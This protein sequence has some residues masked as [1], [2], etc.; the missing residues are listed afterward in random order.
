MSKPPE[1]SPWW[2]DPPTSQPTPP[3][4]GIAEGG[5]QAESSIP[6]GGP[7]K[8]QTKSGPPIKIAP[9]PADKPGSPRASFLSVE[10]LPT[11][12][13]FRKVFRE[14]VYPLVVRLNAKPDE[15]GRALP[16]GAQVEVQP[17]VPGA[18]VWPQ[19]Q[20]LKGEE[21][22]ARFW[23]MPL[24]R[25]KLRDG[26]V[27]LNTSEAKPQTIPIP[28]LVKTGR[29]W[30]FWLCVWLTVL[31]PVG[32]FIV[33]TLPTEKVVFQYTA[34][35]P[36]P[37]TGD[38]MPMPFRGRKAVEAWLEDIHAAASA[39]PANERSVRQWLSLGLGKMK[40]YLADAYDAYEI[41]LQ[42]NM[43]AEPI[44]LACMLFVTLVVGWL[45]GTKRRTVVGS[46]MRITGK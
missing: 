40:P 30:F 29:S 34:I 26:Y 43:L 41:L 7:P 5:A 15:A 18:M 28:V 33:R 42:E 36:S 14:R 17:F 38:D 8:T 23:V 25:G 46:P 44:V 27:S 4:G 6:G 16:Q 3:S 21:Q 35:R 12:T 45:T 9:E 13:Y 22:V 1:K 2:I 10:R 20:T 31:L 19:K 11:V 24:A 39:V 37:T 32:M